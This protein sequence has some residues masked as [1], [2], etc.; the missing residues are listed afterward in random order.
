MRFPLSSYH[1]TSFRYIIYQ[2]F[3][4][5]NMD[6]SQTTKVFTP[7][8]SCTQDIY[9]LI[10]IKY[11]VGY[12]SSTSFTKRCPFY[13]LGPSTSTSDC[14]PTDWQPTPGA[15]IYSDK[16]PS[17]YSIMCQHDNG[18]ESTA[19]CC[20]YHYSCQS[21]GSFDFGYRTTEACRLPMD[22]D[23]VYVFTTRTEGKPP[24]TMTITGN[25]GGAINAFGVEI[26]WAAS[27]PASS[28]VATSSLGPKSTSTTRTP[29][30]SSL[31]SSPSA[32]SLSAGAGAGIGIGAL[33]A[34]ALIVAG[35]FLLWRRRRKNYGDKE[36]VVQNIPSPYESMQP[37]NRVSRYT[38][39]D[40]SASTRPVQFHGTELFEMPYVSRP[41][42]LG[43]GEEWRSV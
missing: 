41:A 43:P 42:E 14:F 5:Y 25:S 21:A 16:C 7:S 35:A 29:L 33:A 36:A 2:A 37:V 6:T 28:I 31:L 4:V 1:S 23:V 8:P 12:T 38:G 10:D 3:P 11:C 26:R 20:P 22:T 17:G 27:D 9:G 13:H 15:F 32:G 24:E 18:L 30:S 39:S 40:R 19:T 34:V